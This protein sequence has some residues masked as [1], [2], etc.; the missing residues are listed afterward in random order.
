MTL[1]L[2]GLLPAVT[3]S[4][5][6]TSGTCGDNVTWT[7]DSDTK[8]LT[9][10][11]TGA[12][13]NYLD[14]SD[15]PYRGMYIKTIVVENGITKIGNAMFALMP[16]LQSVSLPD[17][18]ISLG[19]QCFSGC[20]NLKE[21]TL[22]NC[23]K[24]IGEAAFLHCTGLINVTIPNSVTS[25]GKWAFSDCISLKEITIPDSVTSISYYTFDDCDIDNLKIYCYSGGLVEKVVMYNHI[26]YVI[27]GQSSNPYVPTTPAT[28]TNSKTVNTKS[29][30]QKAS[31]SSSRQASRIAAKAEAAQKAMKQAKITKLTV[32]S[33]AKRTINVT[34]KKV[35][36]AKGYQVQVSKNKKFK[37]TK[38]VFDKFTSKQALKLKR[39]I[40]KSGKK[41]Y[42]R[43]RAY[44][45]YTNAD[46]ERIKVYSAW[47]KKLRKVKVK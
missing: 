33:K 3:A 24:S 11:G 21:I 34:W 4:A 8:T 13:D 29:S 18:L 10:S 44:T 45:A 35:S 47:N 31:I 23:L 16:Y 15:Q 32:K 37:T 42:V 20:K 14:N 12:T 6:T 19:E 2:T 41:Y 9:L 36:T 30:S 38:I 39:A 46:N 40:F 26:N 1:S 43:V 27:I 7:Y 25:I 17:S 22:P 5:D 28:A